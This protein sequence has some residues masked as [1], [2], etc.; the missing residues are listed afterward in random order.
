MRVGITLLSGFF[1]ASFVW[2]TEFTSKY[3]GE[4]NRQIKSLSQEDISD[5]ENG[6]GW[7]L[8]KA[9]ELNGLPGP[10]HILEMENEINLSESQKIE[11]IKIYDQMK[12]TAIDLGKSLIE[13]EK[14]LDRQFS[15]QTVTKLS[16]NQL[17]H[18]IAEV[19]GQLRIVHLAAHLETP[20][21]LRSEQITLYNQLRGYSDNPCDR[22]PQG[23][24]I[25]MW[26]KHNRCS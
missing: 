25:E 2:A 15:N 18:E 17:V 13:L 21:I 8:A 1:I 3:S 7:G 24:S 5:L 12:E 9:A 22:V 6:R 10:V 4:E 19:R 16:L 14:E 20:K 26:R 23:H 11:I